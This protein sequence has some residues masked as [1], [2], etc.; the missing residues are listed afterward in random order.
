MSRNGQAFERHQKIN[1]LFNLR[2]GETAIVTTKEIL[3]KFNISARQW[4]DD[5]QKLKDL[6]A[7][8]IYDG[9]KRGWRYTAPF[10]FTERIPLTIE[11]VYNLRLAVATLAQLNQIADFKDLPQTV[12]KIRKAV[13]RWVDHETQHKAIYFDPLPQ[14][15]GSRHLPFF[16]QA[17]EKEQQVQFDYFSFQAST[18]KTYV[19]DPYFL[20]QHHQRWY[21]GGWSHDPQERFIRTFP[22]ERIE[23]EPLLLGKFIDF[24]VKPPGFDPT[25]YWRQVIGINRPAKGVVEKVVLEFNRVQGK[26]FESQPFYQPYQ[27]LE[28]TEHKLVVHLDLMVE[29]ELIRKIASYGAEVLVLQPEWLRQRMYDFF[30]EATQRMEQ[31]CT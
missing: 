2:K 8:L 21:V 20:R 15:E 18:P 19:F 16:M 29:I 11:D 3:E 6:G 12:D 26:Y 22:L 24:A 27:V 13:G 5:V 23:G 1:D 28:R 9:R 7:P 30:R 31:Y 14:Y 17:I 10:N 4:S 25:T